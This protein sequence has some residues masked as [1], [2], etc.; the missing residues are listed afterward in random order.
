M[1]IIHVNITHFIINIF[2]IIIIIIIIIIVRKKNR[3]RSCV[4]IAII[5]LIK[6][7]W[8]RCFLEIVLKYPHC[9]LKP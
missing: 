4:S 1:T 9:P 8:R 3:K 6:S 7:E 5:L 2:I